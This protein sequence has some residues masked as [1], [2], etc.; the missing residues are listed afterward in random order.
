MTRS[1]EANQ[2]VKAM[3]A[4]NDRRMFERYQVIHLHLMGY[5]Q[6]DICDIV[7]RSNKTVSTYIQAYRKNGLDGLTMGKSTGAP[8]KL[9]EIQEHE[10]VQV[11]AFNTPHDVGFENNYNWTLAIIAA[12][13]EREWAQSYTLRGVSKLLEDLGLSYTRPTYVLKKAD[14]DKQEEFKD[15]TFPTFKKSF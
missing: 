13:I 5:S 10:L 7:S 9:T 6:K 11:V 8:R 2:V 12:F 14:R 3:K 1:Q 15:K 4:T